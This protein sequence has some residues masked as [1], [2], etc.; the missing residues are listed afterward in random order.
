VTEAEEKERHN[1][2]KYSLAFKISTINDMCHCNLNFIHQNKT[3]DTN[4]TRTER[5][6]VPQG[7]EMNIHEH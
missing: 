6:F 7:W 2:S 5:N 4:L 1:M 3:Y